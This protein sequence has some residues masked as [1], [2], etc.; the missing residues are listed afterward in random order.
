[1]TDD[2]SITLLTN[3]SKVFDPNHTISESEFMVLAGYLQFLRLSAGDRVVEK[4][5]T[6]SFA[7]IILAGELQVM[8]EGRLVATMKVG[9][10]FGAVGFFQRNEVRTADVHAGT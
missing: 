6:A 10:F 3:A 9:T 7:S 1:M 8:V 2:E 5:A 4:D